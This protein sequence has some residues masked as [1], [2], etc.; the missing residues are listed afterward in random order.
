MERNVDRRE[1]EEFYKIQKETA[2]QKPLW[3][4]NITEVLRSQV[5]WISLSTH[6]LLLL[7]WLP[8]IFFLWFLLEFLS[9]VSRIVPFGHL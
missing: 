5:G 8:V 2:R 9:R 1:M 7:K 3:M 4:K 6:H